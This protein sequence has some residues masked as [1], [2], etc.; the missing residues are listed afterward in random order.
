MTNP[1]EHDQL[2]YK[3]IGETFTNLIKS[4][5]SAKVISI[6]AGFGRGKTFFRKAWSEHLRQAGEVV[7][8]ISTS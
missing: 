4:I 7:I 6:E 5:D 8:E 2:G 3:A 1:W